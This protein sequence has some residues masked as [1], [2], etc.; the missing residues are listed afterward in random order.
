VLLPFGWPQ[1]ADEREV[2]MRV[3]LAAGA[4]VGRMIDPGP[5]TEDA[6]FMRHATRMSFLR[7]SRDNPIIA[8]APSEVDVNALLEA[9]YQLID[10]VSSLRSATWLV[11]LSASLQSLF[12]QW[13][14]RVGGL[15]DAGG[16]LVIWQVYYGAV[17]IVGG[18]TWIAGLGQ[19]LDE[20]LE[21]NPE[22]GVVAVEPPVHRV[23][24]HHMPTTE[25][26]PPEDLRNLDESSP[27]AA[28][29]RTS[30]PAPDRSSHPPADRS[31]ISSSVPPRHF[32][33]EKSREAS[34]NGQTNPAPRNTSS[35]PPPGGC[36]A[37]SAPPN[38][39][40]RRG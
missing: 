14:H 35:Y 18:D 25:P 6:A 15:F 17:G 28:V 29:S 8:F 36:T 9:R 5:G 24:M 1:Q 27:Y 13:A 12:L 22:S 26:A 39:R 19:R 16:G 21:S 30:N 33:N 23:P 7:T 3:L 10:A 34:N 11:Y 32:G 38:P 4:D 40:L 20:L 2:F 37:S 31:S